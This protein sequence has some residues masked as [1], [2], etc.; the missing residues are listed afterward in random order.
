MRLLN[1]GTRMLHR[2]SVLFMSKHAPVYVHSSAHKCHI[3]TVSDRETDRQT[4]RPTDRPT[5]RQTGRTDH[6][7]HVCAIPCSTSETSTKPG[8]F[9]MFPG[10]QAAKP[11]LHST[12]TLHGVTRGCGDRCSMDKSSESVLEAPKP[13]GCQSS[14][15]PASP[16]IWTE[17]SEK[18]SFLGIPRRAPAKGKHMPRSWLRQALEQA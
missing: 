2:T 6:M 5:D 8:E 9:P 11:R 17:E 14:T 15:S 10:R 16:K 13:H 1:F 12:V 7:H 18:G 4:D 3:S